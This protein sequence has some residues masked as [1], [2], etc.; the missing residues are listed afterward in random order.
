MPWSDGSGPPAAQR[1][2]LE[3]VDGFRR[4]TLPGRV[5]YKLRDLT[6]LALAESASGRRPQKTRAQV[7]SEAFLRGLLATA[8]DAKVTRSLRK[9]VIGIWTQGFRLHSAAAQPSREPAP[10]RAVDGLLFCRALAGSGD[11]R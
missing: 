2:L 8:L 5:P 3:V 11:D 9:A 6:D 1:R 10:E 4:G 7:P